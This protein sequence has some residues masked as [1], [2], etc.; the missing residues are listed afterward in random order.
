MINLHKIFRTLVNNDEFLSIVNDITPKKIERKNMNSSINLMITEMNDFYPLT[1]FECNDYTKFP[2]FMK[3]ILTSDYYRFGIKNTIERNF[4]IINISF[5]NSINMILRPNLR[6]STTDDHVKNFYLLEDYINDAIRCNSQI[7]KIK[8]TKRIKKLNNEIINNMIEGKISHELIQYVVNIFEIN[9][10]IFDMGRMETW[11][12]WAHGWKYPFINFFNDLH[13]MVY[14]HGNYEPVLTQKSSPH[15]THYI[16][17][18]I[19]E[20]INS[21]KFQK[22]LEISTVGLLY[23]SKWKLNPVDLESISKIYKPNY[24]ESDRIKFI[25]D[26]ENKLNNIVNPDEND[27]NE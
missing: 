20:N 9:L 11:F 8:N 23:L 14:V 19:L 24:N 5:L 10:L 2:Q 4:N 7:D 6:S 21:I 13:V 16:Y 22:K 18:R 12:Y 25:T 15:L 17:L 26:I 1:P 3:K 27:I